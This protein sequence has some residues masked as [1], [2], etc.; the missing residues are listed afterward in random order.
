[1]ESAVDKEF[2]YCRNCPHTIRIKRKFG[3]I[4]RCKL[5]PTHMD[6]THVQGKSLFCPL[7]TMKAGEINGDT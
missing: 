7:L 1:M 2:P 4:I 5:E 3:Y 6:V